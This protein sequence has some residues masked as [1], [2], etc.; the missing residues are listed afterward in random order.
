[1]KINKLE[2][3]QHLAETKLSQL[4]AGALFMEMGTGKT[5]VALDL[6]KL[7]E[8]YFD[9]VL[10]IAPASL[11]RS[12]NYKNEIEKWNKLNKEMVFF[13][14]ESIGSSDRLFLNMFKL[15]KNNK[16][17]CIVDESITI[18]NT[19]AKRVDRLLLM[20]QFMEFKLILNGTPLS[21]GLIDLYSQIK[22][23]SPK[24]LN[25]TETQFANHFL[26][27][28][29]THFR[30]W[31]RWSKP[32]NEEALIKIIE[33]YIFKADLNIN[34]KIHFKT[35]YFKLSNLEQSNY[36]HFKENFLKKCKELDF[37]AISTAFQRYYTYCS[38]KASGFKK[39]I[40]DINSRGEFALVFVKYINELEKLE[41][42][43]DSLELKY[44]ILSGN[45]KDELD[46]SSCI[47]STYGTGSLGLN[48]QYINNVIFFTPTFDYKDVLQGLARSYRTG[49]TK[50]VYVYHFYINTGLDYLIK[51]SL[52]KKGRVLDNVKRLISKTE[53]LKL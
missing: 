12:K 16:I 31:R 35:I 21:K 46:E 32:F 2:I 37:F 30:G 40:M 41:F 25:M 8:F 50:D 24:I 6:A 51:S 18:K 27:Y 26:V 13:S 20:S 42:I 52:K 4:R 45:R 15:V 49:Q 33:P 9:K 10:W 1:M 48:L 19:D 3:I 17:F 23:L 29:K 43:F 39:L 47:V 38:A 5:K 36:T 22:F 14:V 7:K 11:L 53:A 28:E 34:V 44:K